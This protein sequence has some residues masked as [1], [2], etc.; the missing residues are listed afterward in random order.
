M[1]DVTGAWQGRRRSR[2]RPGGRN[3][4]RG[5]ATLAALTA[6]LFAACDS[7]LEP[8]G[9]EPCFHPPATTP[10]GV[11]PVLGLGCV[12]GRFTSEVAVLGDWAYTGT[13][14]GGTRGRG[15]GNVLKIWNVAGHTPVLRDSIVVPN[16]QT[17]GDVHISP[18]DRLMVVATE[19][20]PGSVILFDISD[21]ARPRQLSRHTSA[22]TQ[23]G[24]HTAKLARVGGRLYVFAS[25]A[26]WGGGSL[27]TL[28]VTDPTQPHEVLARRLGDPFIHD[29]FVR[30]GLLF[31]ALWNEGTAVWDI[32]GGGAGG[33]PAD[34]RRLGTAPVA[35]SHNVYW[36][37]AQG[38]A[39]SNRYMFVGQEIPQTFGVASAGDIHVVDISDRAAPRVVA[40]YSVPGAG[41]HNF[42]VDEARG[43][44]YAAYYN[45]G[46]RAIDV[47]GDLEAC[48]PAQRDGRGRCDLTRMGRERAVALT[49]L[50][51][52]VY[53]WG[54]QW[55]DGLLYAS[56][57][58]NGLFKIDA[59]QLR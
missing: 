48:T 25:I 57:M 51:R 11:L 3:P 5:R 46:V 29:V 45:G 58:L 23:L 20:V 49:G 1:Q 24:V 31:T 59:R 18:A 44:L 43:V 2:L 15:A 38:G 26:S 41:S 7:P 28:D 13:W 37:G 52:P 40:A 50:G 17:L 30:D 33:S 35:F 19:F 6:L 14:D 27:V 16:A 54:V 47:S 8:P 53:V 42:S 12:P 21:P 10:A 22:S 4:G 9:P 32:G 55:V 39:I 36:S 56:D 34:P